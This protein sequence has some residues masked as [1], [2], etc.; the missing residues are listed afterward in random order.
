MLVAGLHEF[1]FLASLRPNE[2]EEGVIPWNERLNRDRPA[3]FSYHYSVTFQRENS[4]TSFGRAKESERE[5]E[6]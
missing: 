3:M 6:K 2:G 4:V 1:I 5:I